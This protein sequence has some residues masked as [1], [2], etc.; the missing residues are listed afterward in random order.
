MLAPYVDDS[1]YILTRLF[2]PFPCENH[3]NISCDLFSIKN[4]CATT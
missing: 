2:F 4:N 3:Y 1:C